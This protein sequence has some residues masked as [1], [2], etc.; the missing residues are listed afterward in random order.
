MVNAV[1]GKI[2]RSTSVEVVLELAKRICLPILM[3]CSEACGLSYTDT[4]SLEFAVTRFL[5]KNFR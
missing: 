3:N 5:V 2:G 1:F 4:K